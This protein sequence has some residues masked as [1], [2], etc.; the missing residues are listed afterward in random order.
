MNLM[1]VRFIFLFKSTGIGKWAF[2]TVDYAL[3][4]FLIKEII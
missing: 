4:P 1:I 3:I 2:F